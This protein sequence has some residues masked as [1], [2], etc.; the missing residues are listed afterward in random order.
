MY[1]KIGR[2]LARTVKM[3]RYNAIPTPS[4]AEREKLVE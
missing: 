4:Q 1:G 2:R 3:T